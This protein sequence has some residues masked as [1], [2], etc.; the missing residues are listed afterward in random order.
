MVV[1]VQYYCTTHQPIKV[2]STLPTTSSTLVACCHSASSLSPP[3]GRLLPPL[4]GG[5]HRQSYSSWLVGTTTTTNTTTTTSRSGSYCWLASAARPAWGSTPPRPG[6]YQCPRQILQ[7][8]DEYHAATNKI[9]S[10]STLCTDQM[11][12]LEFH[13]SAV[14]VLGA[15]GGGL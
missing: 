3:L 2:S 14:R 4:V 12:A 7:L 15:A 1:V 10:A 11:T 9:F 8:R 13:A 6:C 5:V